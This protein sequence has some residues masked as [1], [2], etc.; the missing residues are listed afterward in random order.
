MTDYAKDK[1]N[2]STGGGAN[3]GGNF[4]LAAGLTMFVPGGRARNPITGTNWE[5]VGVM[6]DVA[7]PAGDALKVALEQLA[8]S[9]RQNRSD[10]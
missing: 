1:S 5:G 2:D 10:P 4:P 3:P 9:Y 6:P 8:V 7:V